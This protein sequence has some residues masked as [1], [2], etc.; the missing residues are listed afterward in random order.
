LFLGIL[1][2]CG[3]LA[4]AQD[5][6]T[7]PVRMVVGNPPGGTADLIA[8]QMSVHF[9]AMWKQSTVV[10]NRPGAAGMIGTDLVAKATPDG[11]TLLVSAPGPVTT[12]TLLVDKLP[13]DPLKD[14]API[15][16]LAIAPSV[17]MVKSALPV[18]SV[19][20]LIALAKSQPGKLNYA[21]SG[22]G[23]P[24]HLH[25]ALLASLAG[26]DIVH[27]PFKGGGIA[28]NDLVGGHV[29]IMFNPIP[30]MLPLIA[31]NRVKALAVTGP[32]RFPG[33]PNVPT[34]TESGL[35]QI[36]STVW[37][38][39]FAPAGISAPMLKRLHADFAHVLGLPDMKTAFG[40]GGAEAVA[41]TPEQFSQF[42]R[43][44]IE[45]ARKLLKASGAK[46]G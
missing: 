2:A 1:T 26:I 3:P 4:Q 19:A 36:G 31:A 42:L 12:H 27:V 38:G 45:V 34:M 40:K 17:L 41:N 18:Q 21:S 46:R 23:N 28:I 10:D 6:P 25:G 43:K 11:Y 22:N 13:Y 33:L 15:T 44:E 37:Y 30:A 5:F 32:R 9:T 20:E 35:P 7:R 24:S 39:A 14:L 16:M 29:E 8:R